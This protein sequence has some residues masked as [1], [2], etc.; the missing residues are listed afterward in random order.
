MIGGFRLAVTKLLTDNYL[1]RW[2]HFSGNVGINLPIFSV[3][4]NAMRPV[5]VLAKHAKY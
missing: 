2:M 5:I 1:S 3:L 4:M